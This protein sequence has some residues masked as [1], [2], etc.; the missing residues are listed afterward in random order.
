MTIDRGQIGKIVLVGL[1]V[2]FLFLWVGN[3]K[4]PSSEKT[5]KLEEEI[6][7]VKKP[8]I[9]PSPVDEKL[10]LE[11]SPP[12]EFVGDNFRN[13]FEVPSAVKEKIGEKQKVNIS[14]KKAEVAIPT[15]TIKGI[16]WGTESP[17]AIINGKIVEKGDFV[18]EVEVLDITKEG[19]RLKF[20]TQ[21]FTLKPKGSIEK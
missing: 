10:S 12:V 5:V 8:D 15:L 7:K 6:G 18:E 11:A 9:L 1:L 19:V 21:E 3:L 20:R 4:M 14:D 17:K 2:V 16:F 13:P